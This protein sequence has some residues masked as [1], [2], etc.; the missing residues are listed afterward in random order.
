MTTQE[1]GELYN[2]RSPDG[3]DDMEHMLRN[4]NARF[5]WIWEHDLE[6]DVKLVERKFDEI[7][8]VD[9]GKT[10]L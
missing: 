9:Y 7:R 6:S 4:L 2:L 10:R 1:C 3:N 5:E 8:G